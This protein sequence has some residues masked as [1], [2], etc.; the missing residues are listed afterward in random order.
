[1][2]LQVSFPGAGTAMAFAAAVAAGAAAYSYPQQMVSFMLGIIAIIFGLISLEIEYV[3]GPRS[4]M[5]IENKIKKLE[6]IE[7]LHELYKSEIITKD[8][9]EK[10]R[11][12]ILLKL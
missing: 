5:D 10:R 9:Y 2:G 8:E 12:K 7:K 6:L 3:S 4:R 11:N 1:V